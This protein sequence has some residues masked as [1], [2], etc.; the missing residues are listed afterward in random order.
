MPELRG[1]SWRGCFTGTESRAIGQFFGPYG[2]LLF[3]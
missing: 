3:R 2:L 1:S